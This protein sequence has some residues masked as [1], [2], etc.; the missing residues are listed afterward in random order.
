MSV[1]VVLL[2]SKGVRPYIMIVLASNHACNA[3][4]SRR[5]DALQHTIL[6]LRC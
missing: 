4:A 3:K 1:I 6:E 2:V 5:F